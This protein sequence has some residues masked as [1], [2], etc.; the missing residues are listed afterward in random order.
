MSQQF[1]LTEF[2]NYSCFL[3]PLYQLF[4]SGIVVVISSLPYQ[5]PYSF[6]SAPSP[7]N[8]I[9]KIFQIGLLLSNCHQFNL[10]SPHIMGAL[11]FILYFAAKMIFQKANKTTYHF[12]HETLKQLIIALRK[13]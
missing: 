3:S 8:F 5:S 12:S 13:D 11:P 4:K 7:G 10:V 9:S 6:I 1:R 2:I